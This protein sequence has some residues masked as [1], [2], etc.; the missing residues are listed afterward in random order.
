MTAASDMSPD[1]PCRVLIAPCGC[2]VGGDITMSGP[3]FCRTRAEADEDAA[4]GYREEV[5]TVAEFRAARRCGDATWH[6]PGDAPRA[7]TGPSPTVAATKAGVSD[8]PDLTEAVEAAARAAHGP[9]WENALPMLQHSWRERLTP[10]IG[11]AYEPIRAA[12]IAERKV[13]R[14][15]ERVIRAR[16]ELADAQ[17]ARARAGIERDYA[18]AHPLL[19][20]AESD[21]VTA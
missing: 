9:G 6:T 3:G 1:A 11:A 21:D 5:R 7:T 12:V 14:A 10:I 2:L 8:V 20:A 17:A 13:E 4:R 19:K 18:S 16:S 15:Q